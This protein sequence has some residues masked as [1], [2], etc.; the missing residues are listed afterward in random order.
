[1]QAQIFGQALEQLP[2]PLVC[3]TYHFMFGDVGVINSHLFL[4]AEKHTTSQEV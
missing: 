1:M 3:L 2:K 4:G